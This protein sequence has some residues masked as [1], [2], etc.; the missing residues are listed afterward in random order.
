V[1]AEG[2]E[3]P[4]RAP[5]QVE[6]PFERVAGW[7]ARY[8]ARHPNTGWTVAPDAVSARSPDGSSLSFPVPVR[9][10]TETTV[11]GLLSH[12][13]RP[14]QLG[15]VVVR[16][17]GFAVAHV[18]GPDIVEIKVGQRHVQGK[19][20][21]GGWSQQRFAR[22]RDN[23]AQA[24]YDAASGYVRQIL[25]PHAAQ[26][27]QLVTGGD[28]PAVETVLAVRALAPLNG[29]SQRWLPGLPDPRR[30][31][32]DR[33]VTAARSLTVDIVDTLRSEGV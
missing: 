25:L 19:T 5:R 22:R 20:K 16:R 7:I 32:V 15:L 17:G 6:V 27:D 9:A 13:S 26:L 8:D 33:A 4:R 12:L 21:A 18:V 29:V 11:D 10:L 30:A 28:K 2:V 24:A 31:V 23:Q 14:W 3:A 1:T